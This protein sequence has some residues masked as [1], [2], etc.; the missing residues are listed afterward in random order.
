MITH[1]NEQINNFLISLPA[2]SEDQ[3]ELI[4]K[5]STTTVTDDLKKGHATSNVCMIAASI[6]KRNPRDLADELVSKL[7]DSN[8]FEKVESAGPGF[9][10]I[11]FKREDFVYTVSQI[12]Q[13]PKDFG[14]SKHGINK[15]I[16]IEF[17]SANPTGPLHVGHGRGAAYGDAIGRILTSSGYTVEKEYYINDAGRQIDILTASVYVKLNKN[18]FMEFFPKNA[19]KGSYIED[20]A[21]A[22]KQKNNPSPLQ[23]ASS[24]I[25]E[26]P[27]DEEKEIDELVLRIKNLDASQWSQVKD[28][29]L[30]SVLES[31]KEDLS[32]FNVGFDHWFYESSLGNVADSGSKISL[33]IQTLKDKKLAF[34]ENGAIWLDTSDSGD[35]KNRVLI[36]DDGRPTYFASDVAYHKNKIDRGFDK[37]INV[38]GADHHGYIKRIEASMNGLGFDKNRLDVQLVQFANL[39]KEG[40]KVKMSTRSGEFYSLKDLIQDIGTDAAR[41]YYLSKQ[42]DQHL[43]FDLDLATSDSKENMFYYIQYAHARIFSLLNKYKAN[44]SHMPSSA[45]S[46]SN[47]SYRQCDKLIHEISRYPSV[48]R[49]ASTSLHPHLIIFYLKDLAHTFHSFYNDNP[50]LTESQENLDSIIL[51][52]DAVKSVIANGLELLGIEPMEKM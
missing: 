51:C 7:K 33:A 30:N 28:F 8:A 50:V 10:N 19:Y 48:V 11:T 9:I 12:N 2:V 40:K 44:N 20:I 49:R 37:L 41:F 29:A 15:S 23:D 17:V 21:Q 6:L 32:L 16:Q 25:K 27:S 36:R 26:L 24:Y 38:W 3:V 39:F 13:N 18:A 4:N 14:S 35:D 46:I 1:I 52:L 5:K 22:F 45:D 43:D 34:E 47:G 42:A 31:I